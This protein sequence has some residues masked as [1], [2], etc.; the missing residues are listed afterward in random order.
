VQADRAVRESYGKTFPFRGRH[1]ARQRVPGIVV[2]ASRRR[3][4]GAL[5]D[6]DRLREYRREEFQHYLTDAFDGVAVRREIMEGDPASQISCCA[7]TKKA[8]LIM[9]PTH[10][11]GAFR[12]LLLG[13][14]TAKVLHDAD[15][16]V[17]TGVHAKGMVAHDAERCR[18][19]LCAVDAGPKHVHVVR[20]AMDFA[21]QVGA[22]LRVIHA[23]AGAERN[24]DVDTPFREFLFRVAAED[25][26]KL[27]DDANAAGKAE[28]ILAGGKA[29]REVHSAAVEQEAD[30]VVIGRDTDHAL[31]RLRSNAYAII[32]ESPCPV[33]SV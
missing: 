33:I 9:M 17:W 21:A 2:W 29:D 30:L 26:N 13:S 32:R 27:L 7:I 22:E 19:I 12:M 15:C 5:G 10:G 3:C 31:G 11:F 25:M 4:K 23:I 18:R 24:L 14:V 28:V 8:G 6:A 16:P 1:A 20:W